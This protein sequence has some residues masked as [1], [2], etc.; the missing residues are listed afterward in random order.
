MVSMK[1]S[2]TNSKIDIP[3]MTS[4]QYN[5]L[6]YDEKP[7]FYISTDSTDI[8]YMQNNILDELNT[9]RENMNRKL[10]ISML[11]GCRNCGA[12]MD[13]D[14]NKPV[15]HCKYCGTTYVIGNVQQNST[16]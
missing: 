13:I 2:Y 10:N 7:K 8:K 9:L 1:N 12:K 4:A 16:Y 14:I 6:D 5:K 15:F 11:H 3:I